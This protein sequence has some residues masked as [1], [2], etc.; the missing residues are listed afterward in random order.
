MTASVFNRGVAVDVREQA[1]AEPVLVVGW[2]SEA[3]DQHAGGR[4]VVS[5]SH[6]IIQLIVYNRAP[7]TGLLIL[8]WLHI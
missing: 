4:R 2:V 5:L 8:H 7:V 1:Q 6:T 3:I